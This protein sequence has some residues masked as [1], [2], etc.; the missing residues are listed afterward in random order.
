MT[1]PSLSASHSVSSGCAL[2]ISFLFFPP[3]PSYAFITTL[4]WWR[5]AREGVAQRDFALFVSIP[6]R[7]VLLRPPHLF[8][9]F[10]PNPSYAFITTVAWWRSARE[11]A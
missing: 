5:S 8:F 7:L 10:S 9:C 4:T 3:S 11:G 6:Q 1:F 2:P